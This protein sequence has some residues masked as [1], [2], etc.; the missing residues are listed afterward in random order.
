M[1]KRAPGE[2]WT[3][4]R[5]EHEVIEAV[6]GQIHARAS[7]LG[8][9]RTLESGP[10]LD[11]VFPGRAYDEERTPRRGGVGSLDG[12]GTFEVRGSSGL[13]SDTPD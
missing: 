3:K 13:R 9:R 6:P 1:I 4:F 7:A 5:A 2:R 12:R 10:G 8:I 11:P